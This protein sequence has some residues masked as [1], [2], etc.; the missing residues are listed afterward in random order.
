MIAIGDV[1]QFK[2]SNVSHTLKLL[3]LS[4]TSAVISIESEKQEFNFSIGDTKRVDLNSNGIEDLFIQL[5]AINVPL[6]KATFYLEN[7][8]DP[9]VPGGESGTEDENKKGNGPSSGIGD[10][11]NKLSRKTIY[12]ILII[13]L[14]ALPF[15]IWGL[16]RFLAERKFKNLASRVKVKSFTPRK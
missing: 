1:I 3:N 5:K 12:T 10:I 2:I 15:I 4:A 6:L 7:L 13:V 9:S 8:N 11:I 16:K 14:I